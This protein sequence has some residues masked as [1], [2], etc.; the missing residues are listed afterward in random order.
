VAGAKSQGATVTCTIGIALGGGVA[1]GWA[2]IGVL[3]TLEA[4]GI[5]PDVVCGTSIGALIGAFYL[6]GQLQELEEWAST[7]TRVRLGRLLDFKFGFG[8]IIA[9]RRILQ[10]LRMALA[11]TT[12]DQLG[13]PFACVATDLDDGREVWL[14]AGR[15]V[16]AVRASCA[17]PG[18]FPPVAVGQRWL[19]DGALA[20][21][22]PVSACR[23]LG[24]QLIIAVTLS[25]AGRNALSCGTDVSDAALNDSR[26]FAGSFIGRD[27]EPG[28][29]RVL[30]RS[31]RIVQDRISSSRLAADPPAVT[32]SPP[33][34]AIGF[35]EFHRAAECIAA[36]EEAARRALAGIHHHIATAWPRTA[37]DA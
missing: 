25:D 22:V 21:P 34:G 20:N 12:F 17:V 2:H 5:I 23:A 16:D 27:R 11:D 18:V 1:R 19:V 24:A 6:A 29:F 8:S 30:A 32:I 37:Q 31:V 7:L 13:K 36:G 10:L 15:V 35:F 9:G 3:R 28:A 4:A 14:R 26:A 33:V